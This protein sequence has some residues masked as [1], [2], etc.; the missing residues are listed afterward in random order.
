MTLKEFREFFGNTSGRW[1]LINSDYSDNGIDFFINQSLRYLTSKVDLTGNYGAYE[2]NVSS[3]NHSFNIPFASVEKAYFGYTSDNSRT[4]LERLT[5]EE[6]IGKYTDYADFDNIPTSVPC[7]YFINNYLSDRYTEFIAITRYIRILPTPNVSGV[8]TV[9]GKLSVEMPAEDSDTNFWL[10]REPFMLYQCVM[11][12]L[13]T[14]WRNT[15]GQNDAINALNDLI[16]TFAMDN[17]EEE[18]N[19]PTYLNNSWRRVKDYV[20]T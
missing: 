7:E 3:G 1:D 8:L 19:N 10:I 4:L 9:T 5:Y 20:R 12:H 13:E 16:S 11:Y 2:L 15:Q 17:V 6:A 18:A 14:A